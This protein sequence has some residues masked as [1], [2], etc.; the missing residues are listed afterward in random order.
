MVP[1]ALSGRAQDLALKILRA[2]ALAAAAA[3]LLLLVVP[4]PPRAS[5]AAPARVNG[6]A[7]GRAQANGALRAG[8]AR[9]ALPARA[10]IAGYPRRGIASGGPLYARALVLE[11]G[12]L[13]Q[14]LVSIEALLIPGPLEQVVAERAGLSPDACLLLAATHTHSGIGGTWDNALAAL[15]GNGHYDASIERAVAEAAA[16]AIREATAALAPARLRWAQ[17]EWPE[18]PAEA[19]SDGPIDSMLTALQVERER[20][21][22]VATLIDYAMH[23]TMEPRKT[24]R[25]SGDWPGA[26]A[27]SIEA[28]GGVALV[29]Q[30]AGG[31]A[32]WARSAGTEAA[33]A[34]RIE[35]EAKALLQREAEGSVALGCATTLVSLPAA[36][37]G[38]AVPWLLRRGTSN[39]LALFS[40]AYALRSTL[41]IDGLTLLGVPGE[42]VGAIA[43]EARSAGA[44]LAVVGLADGYVGYIE[45]PGGTGEAAKTYY[46]EG[47]A[48]A[49]GLW[50]R[51]EDQR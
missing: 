2:V 25:L 33:A 31:N 13:R 18:G 6:R 35:A 12:G 45:R 28:R 17:R 50:R 46:G 14:S 29:L 1:D 42:P 49:L 44:K 51:N 48:Q 27:A 11:A 4:L 16:Q 10:P 23:P 38:P 36:Q 3:M 21:E 43:R 41:D 26:L 37:A 24:E 32:T 47:L 5:V 7:G 34:A 40:D 22:P 39:L 30:G 8:A 9:V 15:A 19:R 20:G